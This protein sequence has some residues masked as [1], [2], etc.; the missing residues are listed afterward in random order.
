MKAP[1]AKFTLASRVIG[2]LALAGALTG[3][4][5]VVSPWLDLATHF[6]PL[7]L[8]LGVLAFALAVRAKG[9]I[10]TLQGAMAALAILIASGQ[11]A[12]ELARP[13]PRAPL[14]DTTSRLRLIQFNAWRDN[15][16]PTAVADW[17]AGQ[18][19]DA[20][21]IE[22]LTPAL[23]QAL[24]ARGFTFIKGVA[25]TALF[26]RTPDHR[27]AFQVPFEDWV[28]IPD[29]AFASLPAPGGA[30]RYVLVATHL[31]WPIPDSDPH[32]AENLAVLLDRQSRQRLILIGDFNLTP[33]SFA[34]RRLDRRLDL[35]RLDR[36]T[37]TWPAS[38]SVAGRSLPSP[39]ILPIDH[40]YAG[41]AWSVARITRGPRLGSDHYPLIADL[42]FRP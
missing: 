6:T 27:A 33:W 37:P 25:T 40:L 29:S 41:T 22:E 26:S 4:G 5:G 35:R 7:W 2:G 9:S 8:V 30:G 14:T 17:I 3:L 21:A 15:A 11:I 18:Q 39:A 20:V 28:L 19:P 10:L 32:V 31:G 1:V 12:P 34:L 36:A 24:C 42:T 16:D 38:V 23:R 13:I